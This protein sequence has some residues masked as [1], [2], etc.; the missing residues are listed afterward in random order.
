[1]VPQKLP[2]SI[3]IVLTSAFVANVIATYFIIKFLS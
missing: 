3:Y 2:M 1:M